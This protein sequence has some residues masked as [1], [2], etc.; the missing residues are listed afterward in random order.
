MTRSI[1]PPSSTAESKF[2]IELSTHKRGLLVAIKGTQQ[3]SSIHLHDVIHAERLPDIK[4]LPGTSIQTSN[5]GRFV[6]AVGN[7]SLN[8]YDIETAALHSETSL[9]MFGGKVAAMSVSN[10]YAV[11]IFH[12]AK[13]PLVVNIDSGKLVKR[14]EYQTSLVAT[15]SN[16]EYFAT[17]MGRCVVVYSLPQVELKSV[18]EMRHL[19]DK[20]LFCAEPPCL[21][22]MNKKRQVIK[23]KLGGAGGGGKKEDL[24][25]GIMDD[26]T[27]VDFSLSHKND[28]L[29]ATTHLRLYVF[30]TASEQLVATVSQVPDGFT[31]R[32]GCFG[33]L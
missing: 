33:Q 22:M 29:V 5:D 13:G 19:P 18:T 11:V 27:L 9:T 17:N 6:C 21:F 3:M 16:D 24:K 15:S 14:L 2:D 1:I 26:D 30:K 23:A 32:Y 28:R 7:T 25:S 8:T 4:C 20:M 12:E 31:V 10:T